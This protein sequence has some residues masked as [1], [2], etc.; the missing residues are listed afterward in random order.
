MATPVKQKFGKKDLLS[1]I[2]TIVAP[3]SSGTAGGTCEPFPLLSNQAYKT[4]FLYLSGTVNVATNN[5]TAVLANGVHKLLQSIAV[6]VNKGPG[7]VAVDGYTLFTKNVKDWGCVP[8]YADLASVNIGN[9]KAFSALF[10]IDF[11]TP[12]YPG[13]DATMH[14]M[15]PGFLYNLEVTFGA[16]T[17]L[18]T[19]AIAGQMT[20]A[21][22]P[23]ID[24]IAHEILDVDKFDASGR[25]IPNTYNALN[26]YTFPIT[27]ISNSFKVPLPYGGKVNEYILHVTDANG[28]YSN[29]ILNSITLKN[30]DKEV[31]RTIPASLLRAVQ[32]PLAGK[33]GTL[34]APTGVYYVDL[35]Y[36]DSFRSVRDTT[37]MTELQLLLD[38]AALGNIKILA[39]EFRLGADVPK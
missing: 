2:G 17:N 10:R 7:P 29:A 9:G 22:A 15:F 24:V 32:D 39:N 33:P 3:F 31:M 25:Q 14:K 37:G 4:L 18:G 38:T 11:V 36:N 34:A 35:A 26:Q 13:G 5:L 20:W 16:V 21:A 1:R 6:T 30:G 28:L 12:R 8:V 23:T 27:A 19:P